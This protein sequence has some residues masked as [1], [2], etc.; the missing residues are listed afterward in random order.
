MSKLTK[1]NVNP[2]NVTMKSIINWKSANT[3]KCHN[4]YLMR[5]L[6]SLGIH[7]VW[8]KSLSE[9]L[10]P[11]CVFILTDLYLAHSTK[12]AGRAICFFLFLSHY[13]FP[14]WLWA[15]NAIASSFEALGPSTVHQH[16]IVYQ[17]LQ[18]TAKI[19]QAQ[20]NLSPEK[21]D[22][23]CKCFSVNDLCIM[24]KISDNRWLDKVTRSIHHLQ[25]AK[26]MQKSW[27][28]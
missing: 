24:W 15:V 17:K 19:Q 4:N 16:Y 20:Y 1:I 28:D 25:A 10:G 13:I 21:I 8:V 3:L 18:I 22:D 23:G 7:Y 5:L 11:N 9:I 14:F 2:T 6:T 12:V 26:W 27:S